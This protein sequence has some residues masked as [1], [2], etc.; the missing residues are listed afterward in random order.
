[1]KKQ[2]DAR[3]ENAFLLRLTPVRRNATVWCGAEDA[4]HP[5]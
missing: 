3:A 2:A 1:M 4:F 5:S